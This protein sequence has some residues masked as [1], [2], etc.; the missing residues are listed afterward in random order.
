MPKT[1]DTKHECECQKECENC[2]VL[3]AKASEMESLY[4]RALADYI[5]LSKRNEEDK[6]KIISFANEILITKMIGVLD[7]LEESQKHSKSDG[8][9]MVINKFKKILNDAGVSEMNPE[10]ESFDPVSHEA[11]DLV[12][13]EKDK[14]IMVNKKGYLLAGKV[15]RPALVSVGKGSS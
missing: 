14:V 9:G 11:L 4:K 2:K 7:D 13:G 8:I 5:N 12:D 15:I 3:E 10:S 1:K 6:F